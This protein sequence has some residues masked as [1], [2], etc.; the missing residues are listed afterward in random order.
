MEMA[1]KFIKSARQQFH[2]FTIYRK[3]LIYMLFI[4]KIRNYRGYVWGLHGP[5]PRCRAIASRGLEF[6]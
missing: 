5:G 4:P 2:L 3:V 6:G 1:V